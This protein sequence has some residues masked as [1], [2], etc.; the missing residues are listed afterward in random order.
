MIET[1]VGIIGISG[2]AWD[3]VIIFYDQIIC[4]LE[5]KVYENWLCISLR[6]NVTAQR[7]SIKVRLSPLLLG[8]HMYWNS[9]I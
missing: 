6:G 5:R 3:V 9:N 7:C 1:S 4:V 2:V 8:L